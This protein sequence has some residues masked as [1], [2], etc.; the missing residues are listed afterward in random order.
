M[1]DNKEEIKTVENENVE[2]TGATNEVANE[3]DV[4]SEAQ[5]MA[6]AIVAKKLAKMPTK[7]QLAKYKDWEEAQKTE[8]EKQAEVLKELETLKQEKVNTQRE[9]TLLKKGVNSDDVDYVLFKVSKM[10]GE[11]E[12]NLETFLKENEKFTQ[13]E[14][15]TTGIAN[16]KTVVN[17]STGVEAI[18]K[19]RHP[20]LFN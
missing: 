12:D 18:L 9:N 19:A 14:K 1:E 8:T 5:K 7:E 4:K 2:V 17:K 3:V 11:F 16:N 20:E 10:D 15:E 6:D 13:K